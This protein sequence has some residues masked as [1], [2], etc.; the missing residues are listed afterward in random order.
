MCVC[1]CERERVCACERESVC[2]CERERAREC[3]RVRERVCAGERVRERVRRRKGIENQLAGQLI[4]QLTGK[5][6]AKEGI[7]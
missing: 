3:V 6:G 2:A 4:L 1:V 5:G 7:L